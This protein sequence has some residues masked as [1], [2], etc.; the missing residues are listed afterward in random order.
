MTAILSLVLAAV[1]QIVWLLCFVGGRIM[2]RNVPYAPFG[3]ASLV[4]I[5]LIVSFIGYG[6]FVGR[7]KLVITEYE[8]HNPSIPSQFDGY[9]VA[10]ISDFHLSTFADRPDKLTAFVDA[11][12]AVDADLICFTGDLV[13]LGL[14]ECGACADDLRRIHAKDGVVSVFG[15]HDFFLYS[16]RD[17]Q[18]RTE[19]VEALAS[20]ERD[21]LGWRLLRNE[22]V[23]IQRDGAVITII[24]VDNVNGSH[25]GFKTIAMGD[26]KK[27]CEGTGFYLAEGDFDATASAAD[28]A[29]VDAADGASIDSPTDASTDGSGDVAAAPA[30]GSSPSTA[31][32]Y[33]SAADAADGSPSSAAAGDSP[34]TAADSVAGR[35]SILLSHDPSHWTGETVPRTSIPLTLSGHTHAAQIRL[36]GWTPA[37]WMFDQTDGRYDIGSQTLIVNVG[38][39]CTAPVRFGANP[40]ISVITLRR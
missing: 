32:D 28:D 27:A 8:Y 20:F 17:E 11:I 16:I 24:G 9:K 5:L 22:H 31:A 6:F 35:F 39:G 14:D 7:W 25:Q 1:P 19:A 40:E 23:D 13:S 37:S 38:L 10:H 2:G 29:V 21:T 4:L 12:N 33:G 30:T 18:R 36:F 34:S 15:N 26:L 3:W